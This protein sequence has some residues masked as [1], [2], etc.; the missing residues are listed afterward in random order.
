MSEPLIR[1]LAD[2]ACWVAYHRATESDRPDNI[3][4]DPYARCLAGERG[5]LIGRELYENAWAVA[6]RTHLFDCAI[7]ELLSRNL[8]GMAVNLGAGLDSRPYRLELSERLPWIE[9]DVPEILEAKRRILSNEKPHCQ[10]QLIAENLADEASRRTLFS[11][12][13]Q[14]ARHILVISE[15]L[16]I[17]LDEDKVSLLA[18]DLH[19]QPHFAY[20]LVEVIP[21]VALLYMKANPKWRRHIGAAKLRMA[22]APSDWRAFYR[23]CGWETVEFW[24]LAQA[25]HTLNREPAMLKLVRLAGELSPLWG[26]LWGKMQAQ[27][28]ESGVALL[29]RA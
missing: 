23:K 14:R 19:A 1:S 28:W 6:V 29:H 4:R 15:G 16:L 24:D 3:F 17:Y 27:L 20:W 18:A 5:A 10:L 13:N 7:R 25:A 21:P 11:R 22:F 8:V 9:I 2:T 26:N 12:L